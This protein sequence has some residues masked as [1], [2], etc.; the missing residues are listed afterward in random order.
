MMGFAETLLILTLLGLLLALAI[1]VA[2]TVYYLMRRQSR[3][4]RVALEQNFARQREEMERQLRAAGV[5][6]AAASVPAAPGVLAP[7]KISEDQLM[8]IGAV[9][10]CHF[11]KRVKIRS[12]RVITVGGG[13]NVWSQ[14]GRAAVQASHS[15]MH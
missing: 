4:L 13:S 7:R 8:I 15:V 1:G 6:E 12:A 9:L 3:E 14:Q 11:G 5:S 10:A 2:G